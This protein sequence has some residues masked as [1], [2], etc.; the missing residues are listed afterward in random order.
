MEDNYVSFEVAQFLREKGFN[1]ICLYVWVKEEDKEPV[2]MNMSS[3]I[4]EYRFKTSV[5]V[6]SAPTLQIVM[7]WLREAHTDFCEIGYD[8]LGYNWIIVD[9]SDDTDNQPSYL[10]KSY[11]GYSTYEDAC[12]AAIKY[13]LEHLIN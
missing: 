2:F 11:G 4:D 12:A 1:S 3:L 5:A 7:K 13:C 9:L 8:D 10:S 6:Y